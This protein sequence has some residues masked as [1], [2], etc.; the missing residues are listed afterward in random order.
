M[1]VVGSSVLMAV[2]VQLELR[3][4]ATQLGL[5]LVLPMGHR[6]NR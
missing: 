6:T 4:I 3:P 5:V 1:E 2:R